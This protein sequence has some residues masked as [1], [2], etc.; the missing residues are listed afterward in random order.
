M[1]PREITEA[2]EAIDQLDD[3]TVFDEPVPH[4]DKPR[5][6]VNVRLHPDDIEEHPQV[7]S[8]TDWYLHLRENYPAG[9]IGVY[10]ADQDEN[11]I[12]A[13][14][15]HQKLN[16]AG[17]DDQPW[18]R[19]DICV[20]RYGH[21]LNETGAVHEPTDARERL[22]WYMD[23]AVNWLQNASRGELRDSG[24]P[25]EVPAFNTNLATGPTIAFNESGDSFETWTTMYGQWGTVELCQLP[26][27]EETYAT[28][29]FR[30]SDATIVYRPKWGGTIDTTTEDHVQGAW[31]LLDEIPIEPPWDPPETWNDLQTFFDGTTTAP[32]ELRANIKP[33]LEDE[34]IKVLLIGFPIPAVVDGEPDLIYWQPIQ[35]RGFEDPHDLHGSFRETGRGPERAERRKAEDPIRWLDSDNWSHDQLTRRGH[36]T[37]WFLDRS[38]LLI[39][40][41]ALGSMVAESLAR[42]GCQQLTIVDNETYEIGNLARH[43]LTIDDVG[44]NK[45]SAVADRLESVAPYVHTVNMDTA[46]PPSGDMPESI[47]SAEVVIDCTASRAL[48]QQLGNIRWNNPVIFCSVAMGRRANRLFCFSTYSR[49]FPYDDYQDAFE[50]WRLQEQVEWDAD[51]DAVPERIG[52]WHPASV[53]RT[54]QVMAWAGTVTRLLD[55]ASAL[56]LGETDFTVLETVCDDDE[57]PTI[58]KATPPFH[59]VMTWEAPESPITVQVPREC[60]RAMY[61]RCRN[62]YP[63]ETGGI[64]A[65]ADPNDHPPIV[66]NT[67]DPP[68]DSI[69]EHT[70]F[71]RGT[72]EV[73]RWLTDA[74]ESTGINYFGEWHYHPAASPELSDRDRTAMKEIATDNGYD[75]RHPLLFIIGHDDADE[76][77]INAYLF[78]RNKKY[79]QLQRVEELNDVESD[80]KNGEEA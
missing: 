65:G 49:T 23:R 66:I 46:F 18:R 8:E 44:R 43:T 4:D 71:L 21:T 9:S 35:I 79:E 60:V 50:L 28:Q 1:P 33:L 77:T 26:T 12:T 62:D 76:Y 48:R 30:D 20:A 34:P 61:E 58:T 5:W 22:I 41:G 25:F 16:V 51:E 3:V 74:E 39:G 40:A 52:C 7:P 37:D 59:D 64:I 47:E 24:D 19:G 67:T 10:P 75:C 80:S 70:R 29:A 2:V 42:A 13:T 15:P 72:E 55:K 68:R 14:F 27:H 63:C 32:Y 54:D 69:Q 11:T 45:A 31:V 57:V 6:V 36:M 17:A 53:I 73:D 78:H 56:S 38:I